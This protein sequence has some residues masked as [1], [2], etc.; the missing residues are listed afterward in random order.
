MNRNRTKD[1]KG[2]TLMELII[3]MAL[4]AIITA[5]LV[6]VFLNTTVRA[7]LRSDIQSARVIQN[8]LDLYSVEHGVTLT[9][10]IDGVLEELEDAGYLDLRNAVTQSEGAEWVIAGGRVLVEIKRSVTSVYDAFDNLT[11]AEKDMVRVAD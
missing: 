8:A 6:P 3:V 11:P 10:E 9:G 5:V 7:R 1:T 4:L 2:F